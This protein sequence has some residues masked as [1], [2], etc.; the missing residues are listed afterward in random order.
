ML[1]TTADIAKHLSGLMFI[2]DNSLSK[3]FDASN[4]K[5]LYK[6]YLYANPNTDWNHRFVGFRNFCLML[7]G[8]SHECEDFEYDNY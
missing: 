1:L 6:V 7:N 4:N 8:I 2:V 3:Y 5:Q